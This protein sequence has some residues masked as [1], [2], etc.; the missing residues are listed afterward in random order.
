METQLQ[1]V[2]FE[3]AKRIKEVG[4]DWETDNHY[5][6]LSGTHRKIIHSTKMFEFISAPTVALA[7]KWARDVKEIP[8]SVCIATKYP[9]DDFDAYYI[10]P[11]D[12]SDYFET[13]ELAESELLNEILTILETNKI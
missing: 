7:L 9:D 13:Y 5:Y 10:S 3:Q 2:N 1:L 8:C 6:D 11:S 4:F 12:S